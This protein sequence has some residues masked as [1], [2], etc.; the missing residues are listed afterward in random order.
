[1]LSVR[2]EASLLRALELPIDDRL[3]HL[4][5]ERRTQ[6][7]Y[8]F[9]L[10]ELAHFLIV[11]PNDELSAI[12]QALGFS[13]LVNQVDGSRFGDPDFSPSSEWIADHGFC[14]EAVFIF[15][16][17]GFGH[18]LLVPNLPAVNAEL[19]ALCSQHASA[20]PLAPAD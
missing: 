18:V 7:G 11:Q 1:M 13:V 15:E 9:D 2:D 12:E 16:D 8:D 14:F 19:I 17:S 20:Q 3:K 5:R 10:T 6:L 4:L